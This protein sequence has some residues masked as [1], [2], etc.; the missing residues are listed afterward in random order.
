MKKYLIS[1]ALVAFAA[2]SVGPANAGSTL[3]VGGSAGSNTA[4]VL[5]GAAAT[6]P[7]VAAAGAVGVSAG[8]SAGIAVATPVGSLSAGVGQTNN[9]G[10]ARAGGIAGP[11]GSFIAGAAG[12]GH[13][14]NV[15]GGFTNVTP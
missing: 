15:G 4:A 1:V 3:A 10:A 14:I 13:G 11:G 9:F 12:N 5:T 8:T 7:A 2:A 6:G